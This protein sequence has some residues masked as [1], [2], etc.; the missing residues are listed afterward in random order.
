MIASSGPVGSM[1]TFSPK[2][3]ARGRALEVVFCARAT[4]STETAT[5]ARIFLVIAPDYICRSQNYLA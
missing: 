5:P 4:V 3:E 2:V 1:P